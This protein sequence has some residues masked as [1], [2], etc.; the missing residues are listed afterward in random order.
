MRAG[1]RDEEKREEI[2][3]EMDALWH[4]SSE[5]EQALFAELSE[6]LYV[7]EGKRRVVPLAEGETLEG[8]MQAL[9]GAFSGQNNRKALE[10]LR[11]LPS[12]EARDVYA[13]G[14]CWER[15]GFF[16][17]AVCFYDFANELEPKAVYEVSALEALERANRIEEAL[18]RAEAIEARPIVSGTL[19][20]EAASIFHRASM[21]ATRHKNV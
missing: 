3:Y 13:M 20:L 6:D 19:L 7:I 8:V 12:L 9:P 15:L 1:R 10:L 16:L 18:A 4:A 21:S 11:K 5:A 14:R 17:A 2:G